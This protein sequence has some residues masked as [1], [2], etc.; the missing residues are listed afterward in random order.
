MPDA[1]HSLD[2]LIGRQV[3]LDTAGTVVYLGTLE[4]V[5]PDGFWLREADLSDRREGHA[6]K[7]LYIHDARRAGIN[8]N[9]RRVFV[10]SH[11]VN[12]ISALD[13]VVAD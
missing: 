12:S 5:R 8:P 2:S 7:E 3:V 13:D 6:T 9:R 4:E 10:F 11:I 1:A